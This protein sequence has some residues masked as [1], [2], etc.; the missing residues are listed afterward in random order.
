M[1]LPYTEN[2][3]NFGTG[4]FCILIANVELGELLL[5]LLLR[6]SNSVF[7]IIL[8]RSLMVTYKYVKGQINFKCIAPTGCERFS[9]KITLN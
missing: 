9:K 7:K 3:E 8:T 5:S 4:V 2:K 6:E 1:P